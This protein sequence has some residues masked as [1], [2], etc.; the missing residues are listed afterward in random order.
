[1][2]ISYCGLYFRIALLIS[3]AILLYIFYNPNLTRAVSLAKAMASLTKLPSE[4]LDMIL[5]YTLPNVSPQ[6]KWC[7]CMD[8]GIETF[9]S[10]K[11][12]ADCIIPESRAR[13]KHE[14][15]ILRVNSRIS[16]AAQRLLY[17][18]SFQI[19][20]R[21]K[22]FEYLTIAKRRVTLPD[23]ESLDMNT[24]WVNVFPGLDLGRVRDF[25]I[26][27][28]PS[29]RPNLWR[30]ISALLRAL[31][32]HRLLP[33][34]PLKKLIV[35]LTDMRLMD[36]Q[37]PWLRDRRDKVH[38]FKANVEDYE[39]ALQVLADVVL[40]ANECEIFLPYWIEH[41]TQKARILDNWELG[42]GA[43]VSFNA[44]PHPGYWPDRTPATRAQRGKAELAVPL[45][46]E[47]RAPEYP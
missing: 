18:Q 24:A 32:H 28:T 12:Q 47:R 37:D 14:Y 35:I 1:M 22:A 5:Y 26:E 43:K 16:T 15:A 21:E 36:W 30:C 38:S 31:A 39:Q 19:E 33:G 17:C 8:R 7:H 11:L 3:R 46:P 25:T 13:V 6:T 41:H 29:D 34:S 44:F 9:R 23:P 27:I 10:F 4:I 45:F 2:W 20:I 40:Q 42:T